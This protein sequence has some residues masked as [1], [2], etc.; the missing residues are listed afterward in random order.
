M[1]R[2]GD[3]LLISC[4]ELGHQPF[5]LAAP[6]GF[7]A[8]A[9]Y[10]PKAIDAAVDRI[11]ET[12]V[13]RARFIG[14]SVPM[15]T[16]MRV[17]MDIARRIRLINPDVYLCFYGLYASLNAD[18]LLSNGADAVIGGEFE[19]PLLDLI[20]GLDTDSTTPSPGVSTSR[21]PASPHLARQTFVKP[22]RS[23]LPALKRYAH[24][25]TGRQTVPAGYTEATRGCLH[26]CLHC[27]ITPVYGGRFFAVPRDVVL[28]DIDQ[29]VEKGAR[30]ITFG[31]PDFLNGPTHA[32]KIL[33]DMHAGHPGLTFD[34]TTKVE[35]ILQHPDFFPEAASLGGLFV[36]SAVEST[37]DLVLE[38]LKKGHTKT[39]IIRALDILEAAQLPM[40]PSLVAFTPWTTLD[41]FAALLDFIESHD[42]IDHIDPVQYAIRLLVPPGSALLDQEDTRTWLG[43]LDEAS[44]TY[45]WQ[46]PDPRMDRLHRDVSGLVEQAEKAEEDPAV[47]FYRIKRLATGLLEDVP[48]AHQVIPSPQRRR[49]PRLTEAW[50]C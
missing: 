11:P 49:V 18:Y 19:K 3:I 14:I 30:H 41:D 33:R 29:Q 9:G 1:R 2:D 50:F 20:D 26:T 31:D 36:V 37:S 35:H 15:H 21:R 22:D 45:H 43:P 28:A 8:G 48:T 7:L 16:A 24:L 42:L 13:R 47:T 38:R 39:D 4:Y 17:G 10:A 12:A 6:L 25:D 32:L 44:F 5:S 46:H 23:A 27:P 34:F 40:R